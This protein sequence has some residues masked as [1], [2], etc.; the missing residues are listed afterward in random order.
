MGGIAR[1]TSS[2]WI[3]QVLKT[4]WIWNQGERAHTL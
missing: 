2:R 4:V 3:I 1:Y